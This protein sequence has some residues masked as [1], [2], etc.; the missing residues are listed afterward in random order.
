MFMDG[1]AVREIVLPETEPETEWV[2][3]R[4][5]QKMSPTRPHALVQ[6]A[7]ATR[8]EACFGRRG[9]VGTE[10]RFRVTPP[11]EIT[12]PLVPDVAYVSYERLRALPVSERDTPPFAPDIAVEIRSPGDR[13]VDIDHKR[14]VYLRAGSE[15]VMIVDPGHRTMDV[16]D[17]NGDRRIYQ[18]GDT[19]VSDRYPGLTFALAEIFAKLDL[20]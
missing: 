9:E 19:F 7:V 20:L 4:A 2:R 10:W 3:G 12:R 13:S 1:S 17:A 8:L 11:G 5:L 18:A 6:L 16:F 15:L 14:E